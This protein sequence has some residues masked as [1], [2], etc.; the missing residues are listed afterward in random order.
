MYQLLPTAT[1][2]DEK[3]RG[4]NCAILPVESFEQ[5]DDYLPLITDIYSS[6]AIPV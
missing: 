3:S 6:I 1:T 5:R 4:A 2:A